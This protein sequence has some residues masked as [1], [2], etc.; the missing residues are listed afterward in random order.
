MKVARSVCQLWFRKWGEAFIATHPKIL[1][2]IQIYLMAG[3]RPRDSYRKF[4]KG[5]QTTCQSNSSSSIIPNAQAITGKEMQHFSS[6]SILA[7]ASPILAVCN[8]PALQSN[9]INPS[10]KQT[11]SLLLVHEGCWDQT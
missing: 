8:P 7:N 4:T 3:G 6:I 11:V 9:H 2:V 1:A 10:V 5:T